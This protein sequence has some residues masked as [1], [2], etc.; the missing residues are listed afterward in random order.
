[1][2]K[3]LVLTLKDGFELAIFTGV[4]FSFI[5]KIKKKQ[6]NLVGYWALALAL[7]FSGLLAY[8]VLN[9]RIEKEIQSLFAFSGFL[10]SIVVIFWTWYESYSYQKSQAD[11]KE[12]KIIRK[13]SL[14]SKIFIFIYIMYAGIKYQTKL[15]LFPQQITVNS[16]MSTGLSTE[17]LLKY[18]GGIAGILLAIGFGIILVQ[19]HKKMTLQQN[20]NLITLVHIVNFIRLTILSLYGLMLRGF[21]PATPKF[22]SILAPFYNNINL[23]FYLFVIV[24]AVSLIVIAFKKEKLTGIEELNSAQLRKIKSGIRNQNR[25]A[26]A[27]VIAIGLF[28][29]LISLNYVYANQTVQL[30]PATSL[31]PQS[32]EFVI[33][34]KVLE[35]NKLHRYSYQTKQGTVIEFFLIKKTEDAYGVV[36]DACEICG[37]AGYYQEDKKVICKECDV[38]MNKL[39]IGFPGGC[40]PIPLEYKVDQKSIKIKVEELLKREELF[41]N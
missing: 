36:Y 25:W 14:V 28:M 31:K 12:E 18:C 11:K 27:S 10:L 15:I 3:I 16:M 23:F 34:R 21:I 41:A 32:G 17:L 9:L 7:P 22:I 24:M 30:S 37:V 26:K 8:S 38:V 19:I 33:D 5:Y 40:N 13:S 4:L 2:L 6:L 20:R 35:D 39:T 29:V 1:M